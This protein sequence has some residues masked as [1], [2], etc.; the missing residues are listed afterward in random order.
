MIS[1]EAEDIFAQAI[2]LPEDE[3]LAFVEKACAGNEALLKEVLSLLKAAA[4]SGDYFDKLSEKVS[5]SSMAE[6]DA[7]LP[8]A[9]RIGPWRLQRLISRGGMGAVYL[10]QRDDG[11]YQQQAALKILPLGLRFDESRERFLDERQILARLIH[12]NIARL[13]DG[14]VTDDGTPYFVMDYVD[15][16]PID[17]YCDSSKLS[18]N[19]VLDLVLKVCDAIEYA[20]RNLVVHRDIKPSNILVGS[21]GVPKLLDFGVAKLLQEDAA[22]AELTQ[23]D[24]RPMTVNYSSPEMLLHE[25]V[26]TTTDV[27]SLGVL[28]YRLLTGVLPNDYSGLSPAEREQRIKT[29]AARL[30]SEASLGNE[31]L[32]VARADTLRGDIDM[33]LAKAMSADRERR[34]SSVQ[35]FADDIRRFQRKEPVLARRPTTTY[36]VARFA[37]RHRLPIAIAST[38]ALLLVALSVISVRFAVVTNRQAQ[39][40]AAERD[41]AEEIK[42]FLQNIFWQAEPT[43]SGGQ[44]PTARDILQQGIANL[45]DEFVDRPDLRADLQTTVYEVYK[46]MGRM[47]DGLPL[48]KDVAEYQRVVL[49]EAST[50][51]AETLEDIAFFEERLG[52]YD[53]ALEFASRSVD[54]RRQQGEPL[55]LAESLLTNGRI[56]YRQGKVEDAAPLYQEAVNLYEANTDEPTEEYAHALTHLGTVYEW[57]KDNARAEE[58]HRQVLAMRIQLHGDTSNNLIESYHNLGSVLQRQEKYEDSLASYRRA[59]EIGNIYWPPPD[60]HADFM[61]PLNGMARTYESMQ[62]WDE[63]A[64]TYRE[65]LSIIRHHLGEKHPAYGTIQFNLGNMLVKARDCAGATEALQTA[66]TVLSEASPTSPNIE[67]ARNQL[68]TCE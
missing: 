9:E 50:E 68:E 54:A 44:D 11:Q 1:A 46:G 58:T 67:K 57:R 45:D 28:A 48:A 32:G 59:I 23:M 16:K 19:G 22:N 25:P 12:D 51:Y 14:G 61:Y 63:S 64:E 20:H 4:E 60:R 39:Q 10:A 38:I 5:L 65:A 31:Q 26:D 41:R 55:T 37:R 66:I 43:V 53:A 3:R 24:Q 18:V 17:E 6:N 15:G 49:G 29:S 8:E 56:L 13:L 35:L 21:D 40:I 34:Y 33:I 36:L 62:A 52:N 7:D 47:A 30:A 27:Y 42:D 2:E